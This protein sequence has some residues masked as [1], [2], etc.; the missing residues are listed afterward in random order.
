M[1]APGGAGWSSN[2]PGSESEEV[3]RPFARSMAFLIARSHGVRSSSVAGGSALPTRRAD[4]SGYA[5]SLRP[6]GPCATSKPNCAP[7]PRG[8]SSSAEMVAPP[9]GT[10]PLSTLKL[11]GERRRSTAARVR[12][13]RGERRKGK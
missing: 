1:P 8:L 10:L 12:A 2:K 5:R 3:S 4:V 13:C 7:L 11:R 6:L 9:R